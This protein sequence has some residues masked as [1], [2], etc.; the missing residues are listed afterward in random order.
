MCGHICERHIKKNN[1]LT[2]ICWY[3]REICQEVRFVACELL[4]FVGEMS[5]STICCL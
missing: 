4:V 2:A 3:L 5:R 1:L